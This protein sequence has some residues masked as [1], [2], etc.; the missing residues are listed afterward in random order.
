MHHF[1]DSLMC[2]RREFLQKLACMAGAIGLAVPGSKLLAQGAKPDC[3][4]EAANTKKAVWEKYFEDL[5]EK[6]RYLKR[7]RAKFGPGVAE[8]VKAQTAENGK[9]WMEHADIPQ[10]KRNLGEVKRF[11]ATLSDYSDVAFVEDTPERLQVRVTRCRWQE[12]AKKEG[13]DPELGYAMLCAFDPG[14]CAGLN[15]KIKFTR[16]KTLMQG[17][18]HCNHTY[19]LKA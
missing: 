5:R 11:F 12:E 10:E 8:E 6:A 2:H 7:L 9:S 16:T 3:S 4:A 13:V 18:D 14:Y 17:D 1:I 15:P 19:E